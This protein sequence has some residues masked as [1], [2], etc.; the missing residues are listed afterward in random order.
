MATIHAPH[1]MHDAARAYARPANA[2]TGIV[3]AVSRFLRAWK[4]RR[5]FYRL[6]EMSDTELAD[7]GLTR[8]DLTVVVDLPFGSD[9]TAHLGPLAHARL[10]S[11][12]E[13]ARR[14]S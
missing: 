10:N 9:P 3:N 4:N 11:I 2:V 12:E 5:E 8:S 1:T 14:V 6:G 7:I 13:M